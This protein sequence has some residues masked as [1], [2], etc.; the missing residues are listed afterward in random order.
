[1]SL[2]SRFITEFPSDILKGYQILEKLATGGYSE[3]FSAE[4]IESNSSFVIKSPLL[5]R[6]SGSK[7]RKE[8]NLML[9]LKDLQGVPQLFD[10]L[11][12]EKQ[13]IL[14]LQKLGKSMDNLLKEHLNFSLKTVIM[15]GIQMLSILKGIHDKGIIHRDI[16]P[17]NI[18]ISNS[19][20]S[21]IYLIDY[22]L[23]KRFTSK[24]GGHKLFN[25]KKNSF[26]GTLMFASK[27]SHLGY[28]NSR[29]DDL[30]S[31]AYTL[32][33][34]YKGYL[35]WSHSKMNLDV[36][37]IGKIKSQN[38]AQGLFSDLPE[39]FKNFFENIGNLK[40]E[41]TPDYSF[42]THILL[43]MAK[44]YG[45][46]MSANQWEWSDYSNES[47]TNSES[48]KIKEDDND[49]EI[50][51]EQEIEET[52]DSLKDIQKN[53]LTFNLKHLNMGK[54]RMGNNKTREMNNFKNSFKNVLQ[55]N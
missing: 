20:S 33:F 6:N 52:S 43:N 53:M 23:S 1:M 54:I 27:N 38:F 21:Q 49:I 8:A 7:L 11:I 26:K 44:R 28:S 3:I 9:E 12:D 4:S 47:F 16:K 25:V 5:T 15:I 42:L 36:R 37:T 17:S 19:N 48:S 22:G 41:E 30:E 40:Y 51:E 14:I 24:K 50:Y 18:L 31:L 35:P 39:E 55:Q 13:E 10:T 46:D 32:V 29:R 2:L 45:F 34:L